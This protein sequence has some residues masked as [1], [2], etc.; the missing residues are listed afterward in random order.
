[1]FQMFRACSR[2]VGMAGFALICLCATKALAGPAL[3]DAARH[4]DLAAVNALLKHGANVDMAAND[5]A[6]ALAWATANANLPMVRTLLAAKANPDNANDYG[7][8]PLILAAQSGNAEIARALVAARANPNRAMWTGETALM[9]AA[10]D[11]AAD[12]AQ[13]LIARGA[14]VNARE[15]RHGQTALMWAAGTGHAAVVKLLLRAKADIDVAT[16]VVRIAEVYG[17]LPGTK[18]SMPASHGGFTA[19]MFAAAGGDRET[20]EALLAASPD[21]NRAAA[22]GTTPLL[23]SLYRHVR[24]LRHFPHDTEVVG[25][26]E[27]AR[28]LL[29][30]GANPNLADSHGLTPLVAAVF[31][32]HGNDMRGQSQDDDVVLIPHDADAVA[33]ARLLLDHGADPGLAI[34]DYRVPAPAGADIRFPAHYANV[35]PVLL[36]VAFNKPDLVKL[37][38]DSG[39]YRVNKARAGGYAPLMDAAQ[40]NSLLGVKAL[41]DAGADINA[42][43][44][45]GQTALHIAAAGPKGADEIAGFLITK[46][47]R[48]DI[49]DKAGRTPADMAR[50]AVAAGPRGKVPV[51]NPAALAVVLVRGR[52]VP[53][54][55]PGAAAF[56]A[57]ADAVPVKPMDKPQPTSSQK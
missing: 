15:H 52:P 13:A 27:V 20:V 14:D 16:P 12:I 26:V 34:G 24:P 31:M 32:A 4:D 56:V 40:I 2:A 36:A 11:G 39:R 47:A 17:E 53:A 38:I 29:D 33:A 45:D 44:D 21:V 23:Q 10:R 30:H 37:M 1:M 35:S 42:I 51:S 6:T 49:S 48:T 3:V 55:A 22:D 41:V 25:D 9:F 7:V 46:G 28:V 8:T 57:I 54:G 43:N 19:L 5:G 50:L 18:A